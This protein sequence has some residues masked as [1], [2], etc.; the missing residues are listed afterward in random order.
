M[1]AK[2]L[3]EFIKKAHTTYQA[4]LEAK[5]ILDEKGFV[6][7]SFQDTWKLKTNQGYYI[8][9]NDSSI[10]AFKVGNKTDNLNIQ[11]VAS[12]NDSPTFKIKPNSVI[13]NSDYTKLNTEPYG[14]VIF[15]SWMDKPLGLAGKVMVKEGNTIKQKIVALAPTVVIPTV[16]IHLNREIN[17]KGSLNAK[18]DMPALLGLKNIDFN[19]VIKDTVGD[20]EILDYDLF[21]YNKEEGCLAGANEELICA[22]RLDNLECYYTSLQA[23]L[24]ADNDQNINMWAGFNNEEVGASNNSADSTLLIDVV[25]GI[26]DSFNISNQKRAIL[27]RSMMISADNA[28]AIHPNHPEKSDGTNNVKMNEGVVIKYNAGLS[29]TTDSV[30][31]SIFRALCDEAKVPY[32]SYTNRSDLRGGGTLG[33]VLLTQFSVVSVDIGLAQLAMHS[34]F[35]TA[36]AADLDAMYK[37]LCQYYKTHIKICKNGEI[38]LQ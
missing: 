9:K 37:A 7:L 27:A 36:G 24:S 14:G 28:H 5:N 3:I 30:S 16:A 34:S 21:L 15:S 22:P 32:Q 4:T 38:S 19:K 1:K 26:L 11:L 33:R 23:F 2:E 18:I 17:E 8:T 31:G 29:Y 6:E 10:I 20:V 35:E 12:H 25:D 13:V